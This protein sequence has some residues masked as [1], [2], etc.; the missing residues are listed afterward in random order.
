MK[1]LKQV[2]EASLLDIDSNLEIT[3]NDIQNEL[4]RIGS[5]FNFGNGEGGSFGSSIKNREKFKSLFNW[6][7][8]R[9]YLKSIKYFNSYC[10]DNAIPKTYQYKFDMIVSYIMSLVYKDE[11]KAKSVNYEDRDV[12]FEEF[13]ERELGKFSTSKLYIVARIADYSSKEKCVFIYVSTYP[14]KDIH[15]RHRIT[16]EATIKTK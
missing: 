5:K 13:L 3:D 1:S 2:L 8:L 9:K 10:K 4:N 14:E 12:K 6:T 16:F 11:I 7:D 15:N